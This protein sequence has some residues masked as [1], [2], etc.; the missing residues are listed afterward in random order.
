M[1]PGHVSLSLVVF[2][3]PLVGGNQCRCSV[4]SPKHRKLNLDLDSSGVA[5]E[6]TA[7]VNFRL[8]CFQV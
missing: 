4:I 1:L 7:L 2:V 5:L 6:L 3:V 8:R